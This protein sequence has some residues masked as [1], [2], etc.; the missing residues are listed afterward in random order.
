MSHHAQSGD[1]SKEAASRSA[2][3]A[4]AADTLITLGALLGARSSVVTADF[5]KTLIEFVAVLL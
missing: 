4:G 2:V 5:F 3:L 1:G